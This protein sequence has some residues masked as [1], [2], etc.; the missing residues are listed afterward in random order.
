MSEIQR[1]KPTEARHLVSLVKGEGDRDASLLDVMRFA[2]T[3]ATSLNTF[4]ESLDTSLYREF[5]GIA[6]CIA[7]MRD[8]I[9]KLQANDLTGA[10]IPNAG[11][12]LDAIVKATEEATNTIMG[13]AEEIMGADPSDHDAYAA[14]VNEHILKIFEACSFQDLTGQRISR[15]VETLRHIE[16]RVSH[17]ADA[18]GAVDGE[19]ELSEREQA[20][21]KRAKELILNGPQDKA[22]AIEQ[23][24]VD[25][26]FD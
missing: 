22:K 6:A 24:V 14:L 2:E 10:H 16:E 13:S 26:I 3:M 7:E 12:E 20:R 4:F 8:E 15:V 18:I 21:Q 19:A 17:F 25:A 5:Q 9:G 11:E 1:A 23:D